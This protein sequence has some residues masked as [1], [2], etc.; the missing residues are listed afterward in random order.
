MRRTG[1]GRGRGAAPR[2]ARRSRPGVTTDELDALC[3][4]AMHRGRAAT[5]ARSTTTA[6]PKSLCTSV[7]EVICHG[8]PDSRA[9]ARRRHR[10]PRRHASSAR[11]STAT[12]TPPS[13]VGTVDPESQRLVR[14]TR[15]CLDAGHRRGAARPPDLRHRPGH[16]GPRRGRRV[17]RGALVHRPRHRRDVPHRPRDPALLRPPGHHASWSRAWSSPSSR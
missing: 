8:I 5:R 17:R 3:H 16:P 13:L 1:A 15:E 6:I 4:E 10:Q 12:P 9:A 7:N 14:V 2:S 11:A